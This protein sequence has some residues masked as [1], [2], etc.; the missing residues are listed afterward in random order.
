MVKF[1]NRFLEDKVFKMFNIKDPRVILGPRVGE[2]SAIVKVD[3]GYLAI[4]TDPVTGSINLLGWLAVV[5][6]SNDVA[7]RGIKPAWLLTTLIMPEGS[8]EDEVA[9]IMRQVKD[10]SEEFEITLIGGHTEASDSVKRPIV[11]STALGIGER[12][13]TTSGLRPGDVIVMTKYAAIEATAI[14]ASDFRDVVRGIIGG[15]LGR[16]ADLY[17]ETSVIRDALIASK[18]ATSMH[19][20]TEGGVIQGLIEVARASGLAL[21][22]NAEAIPMMPETRE[23]FK[24]L[25]LDPLKSLSSGSLIIGVDPRNLNDLLR[26]L[27]DNGIEA[28]VIGKAMLG[29]PGLILYRGGSPEFYNADETIEDEVIKLWSRGVSGSLYQR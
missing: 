29:R 16:L 6:P 7:T 21:Y 4:H 15:A 12:Y 24:A 14:L 18:Y 1:S 23:V 13:I 10:A 8:G 17:R 3:S 5:V 20:P 28:S 26:E 11:V 19:D 2:D 9:A 27:R 25:G 22:V